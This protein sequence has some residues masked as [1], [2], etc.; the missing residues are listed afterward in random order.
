M[1][2][3]SYLARP[4]WIVAA[5][6]AL[7][8]VA[9]AALL[10]IWPQ[11]FQ[12]LS[13]REVLGA[14]IHGLVLDASIIA[15][16]L[17]AVIVALLLPFEFATRSTWRAIW[18]WIAYAYL[19]IAV[20]ICAGDIAYFGTVGRHVGPELVS[21]VDD[22]A[23]MVAIVW[24]SYRLPAL[25]MLA[26]LAVLAYVWRRCMRW[27]ASLGP[28][29]APAWTLLALAP[30]LVVA[31]RGNVTGKPVGI[32]DAFESGSVPAGY[33]ALSGPFSVA[34]SFLGSAHLRTNFMPWDEA[35]A[36][37][38]AQVFDPA[39]R[40]IDPLYPL[41]RARGEPVKSHPNVVVLLLESWDADVVDAVRAEHGQAALGTTPNFD[42]LS[43]QGVLFT[44]LFAAGQ[45]STHGLLAV[46]A[47]L[48]SLPGV[49]YI[50]RGVEQSRLSYLGQLALSE[51]YSTYFLQGSSERSFR[52]DA[53]AALA[54]FEH[55]MGKELIAV[56]SGHESMADWGAW[57]H[58]LL[59][60]A[61][62][63][64][65]SAKQPFLGMAFTASTHIPF[66][67]PDGQ[68]RPY[69]DDTAEHSYWNSVHYADWA[70]GEFIASTRT[71][72]YFDNTIFVLIADHCSGIG[73]QG[74]SPPQLHHI[75]CLV[76]APGLA[77][78]IERGIRSQ[79][80]VLATVA[81]LAHW[82]TAYATLGRSLVD[83]SNEQER[84][85]LCMRNEVV[86]RIEAGG[87]VSHDLARRLDSNVVADGADLGA[88]EQR[89]LAAV[90]V[91][92]AALHTNRVEPGKLEMSAT[93]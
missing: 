50:G 93:R 78:R 84:G 54:G 11:S 40:A 24:E 45:R 73:L 53:I 1:K 80:D 32:V 43:Q 18:T 49:P 66:Q 6:F 41:L 64:F 21:F 38:H 65:A 36:N 17:G 8:S 92:M 58:D 79:L 52:I 35:V 83:Q 61:H 22:P 81:D 16:G 9:R 33:L 15:I 13:S 47:G 91:V 26:L 51:G 12:E 68:P 88:I 27:D 87:W 23:L 46:L 62:A 74:K 4:A 37:V 31:M 69:P 86:M 28:L 42:A 48:P 10:W 57:D 59:E 90:Q 56:A 89:L 63:Q 30:L 71:A 72:G 7:F 5:H 44:N 85:A 19:C 55:Y 2:R 75:P 20:L 60:T 82:E 14:C 76:V 67:V 70:L 39:D 25:A 3:W 29:R 77:A 34:H